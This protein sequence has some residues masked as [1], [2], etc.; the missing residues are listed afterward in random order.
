[1]LDDVESIK[2]DLRVDRV[3]T[4]ELGVRRPHVHAHDL[5]R[6]TAAAAHFLGEEFLHRLFGPILS[7][8]QQDPALQIINH[9]EIDL[10]LAPAHLIDANHMHRRS[11][12]V[13][14][15]VLDGAL[16][17][18]RHV[19]QFSSYSRAVPCQLSSRASFATALARAVVTRAHG[20]AQGKSST[21]TP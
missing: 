19:F 5:E 9:R 21:R 15:A 6:M 8:P 4:H 18:R 7:D 1:M 14:E 17:N 20:S 3:V 10:A 16:H 12:A 2:Q 13:V 11:C